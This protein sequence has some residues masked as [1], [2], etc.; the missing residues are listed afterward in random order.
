MVNGPLLLLGWHYLE[1]TNFHFTTIASQMWTMGRLL[2]VMIGHLIPE[3]DTHRQHY[4][5][6]L[7]IM[8]LAFSPVVHPETPGSMEVLIEENLL[9]FTNLYPEQSV[10]PKM[11]MLI[12]I[13][14]FLARYIFLH[15]VLHALTYACI[16]VG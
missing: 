7:E 3:D 1:I 16:S 11:H 10:N 15:R 14:H 5:Q 2:P 12:H 8:D 13:P 9:E 6:L 4:L